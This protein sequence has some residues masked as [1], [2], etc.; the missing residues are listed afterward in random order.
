MTSISRRKPGVVI[1]IARLIFC[2]ALVTGMVGGPSFADEKYEEPPVFQAKDILPADLLSSD[3][4]RVVE[5]VQNDGYLNHYR[6]QS[7]YGEFDAHGLNMLR[8]RTREVRALAELDK[9]SKTS[10][11]LKSAA[12]AGVKQGK[13]IVN[14]ALHPVA[15]VQGIPSGLSRLFRR[16]KDLAVDVYEVGKDAVTTEDGEEGA[17]MSD[18]VEEA[19]ELAEDVAGLSKIERRW[20]RD[21]G[22]DPYTTNETLS[23]AITS[24]AWVEF[25]AR[26]G[27]SIA[28]P[29]VPGMTY[30]SGVNDAVWGKDPYE[31]RDLN[32]AAL[33]EM[34]ASEEQ[35]E[36]FFKAPWYTSSLETAIVAALAKMDGTKDRQIVIEQA[37]AAQSEV[38]AWFFVVSTMLF[39]WFHAEQQPVDRFLA[40]VNMPVAVTRDG[41]VVSIMPIE[42]L[43]WTEGIAAAADRFTALADSI[44][45]ATGREMWFGGLAS[46]RCLEELAKRGWTVHQDIAKLVDLPLDLSSN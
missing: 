14:V 23:S 40:G 33:L 1:G 44:E 13:T 15:T 16:G 6:I 45:G 43:A 32:R 8:I 3:H 12:D 34:G 10:V 4:H 39:S 41:V 22:V 20:A 29:G 21:L 27:A 26:T 24:V 37:L 2:G 17:S 18:T 36:A 11:F 42:Y 19:Q 7:D 31:L 28:V 46:P 5:T 30:I 25:A 9:V 38:D 35:A